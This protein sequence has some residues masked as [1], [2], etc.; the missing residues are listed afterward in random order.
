M[1]NKIQS[2]QRPATRNARPGFFTIKRGENMFKIIEKQN[3]FITRAIYRGF[4]IVYDDS[5]IGHL[6]GWYYIPTI[7][8][9]AFSIQG[10]KSIISKYINANKAQFESVKSNNLNNCMQAFKTLQNKTGATVAVVVEVVQ[11]I[12][13]VFDIKKMQFMQNA[14]GA[15]FFDIDCALNFANEYAQQQ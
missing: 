2:F 15:R 1:N 12:Y 4:D 9:R 13:C 11:D 14:T 7:N 3:Q 5:T 6:R 10:A 8:K